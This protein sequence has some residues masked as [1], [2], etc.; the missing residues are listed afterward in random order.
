MATQTLDT[1]TP[2]RRARIGSA[3][4]HEL[5]EVIPPT[6]FFF[7]GFN[8]IL[9]TKRL[10]LQQYLIEFT[11]FFIATTGALIVGKVV[12]V[13]DKMPIL[14]RFDYAPLAY[15]IVFKTVVYT[16][17]VFVVRLIEA[18]IHYLVSG[19]ALGGGRFIE[20]ALGEFSWA[21]FIATQMWI[22]VL[23]LLYVAAN[24]LNNLLGDGELFRIFFTRPSTALKSTRRARIRLLTRLS[25]LTDAHPITVLEDRQSAPH[26]ELIAILRSLAEGSGANAAAPVAQDAHQ[27]P[28][29]G[30][31]HGP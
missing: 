28:T 18:F 29:V 23:F 13:A 6:V 20:H 26:R 5:H 27:E 21:R 17:L 4:L 11:G 16:A 12:L 25:R 1:A 3:L 19:G 10:F 31:P 30:A 22:F 2:S 9:F 15:P 8:L 7:V 24:E 14:R